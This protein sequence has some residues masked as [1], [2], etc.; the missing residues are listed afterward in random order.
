MASFSGT[1]PLKKTISPP[2]SSLPG[3][4]GFNLGFQLCLPSVFIYPL[5]F[6][7]LLFV[8]AS[9][10]WHT[11]RIFALIF[12]KSFYPLIFYFLFWK[13][14]NTWVNLLDF[15]SRLSPFLSIA[16]AFPLAFHSFAQSQTKFS[17]M[18]SAFPIWLLKPKRVPCGLSSPKF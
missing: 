13:F 17:Y 18:F 3:P 5:Q 16:A 9:R 2:P 11:F 12:K 15:A 7:V 8:F 10:I 4:E 6:S 14:H 1:T